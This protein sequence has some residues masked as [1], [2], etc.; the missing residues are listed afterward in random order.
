MV[1]LRSYTGVEPHFILSFDSKFEDTG[2]FWTRLY[3]MLYA[4]ISTLSTS[5][6]ALQR[7][8][9]QSG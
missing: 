9:V 4:L 6:G 1:V 5:A 7:K 8:C 2:Q 3:G